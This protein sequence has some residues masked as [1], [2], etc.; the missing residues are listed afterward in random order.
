[1]LFV[2][3]SNF[4]SGSKRKAS[5]GSDVTPDKRM[6]L[7]S[8]SSNKS[9]ALPASPWEAKRLKIDL[10]GAKAQVFSTFYSIQLG[11]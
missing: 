1:M 9:T 10:I 3:L 6:R 5:I 8:E 11:L 2:G 4:L 7:D